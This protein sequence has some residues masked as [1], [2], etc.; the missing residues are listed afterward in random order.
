MLQIMPLAA[1]NICYH[2][3]KAYSEGSV[4]NNQQC[5]CDGTGCSWQ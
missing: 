3:G 5:V 2:G 4:V 1:T